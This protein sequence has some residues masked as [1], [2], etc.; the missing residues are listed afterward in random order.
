MQHRVRPSHASKLKSEFS[1]FFVNCAQRRWMENVVAFEGSKKRKILPL[2]QFS[3][4]PQPI[5]ILLIVLFSCVQ[6]GQED[7]PPITVSEGGAC[8][9]FQKLP[10]DWS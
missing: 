5:E 6:V 4:L 8:S 9:P 10:T 3:F 7:D 1:D 2:S